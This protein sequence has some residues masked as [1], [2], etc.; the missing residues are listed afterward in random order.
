MIRWDLSGS[1]WQLFRLVALEKQDALLPLD[2]ALLDEIRRH[3]QAEATA[4]G[5]PLF[6]P[7]ERGVGITVHPR[8]GRAA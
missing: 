6:C 4:A 2:R 1:A 5:V 8:Q 3:L 7:L